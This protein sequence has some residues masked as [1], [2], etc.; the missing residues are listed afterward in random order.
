FFQNKFK[1]PES[2]KELS[3][4]IAGKTYDQLSVEIKQYVARLE[5]S[6]DRI[7]NIENPKDP[8]HQRVATEIFWR[9]QQG[10]SLNF[11]EIAHA[12]LS[13]LV[14]NFVVKYAD[15]YTFDFN[16]YAPADSNKNKHK[17]FRIYRT[18]N[19]R[20]QHLLLMTRFLI[21][22]EAGGPTELKDSAVST[23]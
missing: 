1:L 10:E 20:M 15:D 16:A 7:T 22:E 5:F 19:E 12:R 2:L 13:S 3:P 8:T 18:S 4:E 9:L 14:R 17:F 6:V 23:F 11:M 21:L